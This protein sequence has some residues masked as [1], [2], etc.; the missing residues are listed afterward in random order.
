M[1]TSGRADFPCDDAL[2][3]RALLEASDDFFFVIDREDRVRYVNPAAAALFGRPP[4][5]LIG[6]RRGGLFPPSIAESQGRNLKLVFDSGQAVSRTDWIVYPGGRV[7]VNTRLFPLRDA[8][9]Q[10]AMV[11]GISR[12][13]GEK[14]QAEDA[15]EASEASYRAVFNAANDA[16]FIHDAA[17]GSILDANQRMSELYGYTLQEVLGREP[18]AF[19]SGEPPYTREN[20]A[21]LFQKAAAGEDQSFEWRVRDRAGEA[22]WVE[23]AL[24]RAR[25]GGKDCVLAVVRDIRARKRAT[26][27]LRL[28]ELQH[29]TTLDSL[30]DAVHVTD[31]NFRLVLFNRAFRDWVGSLGFDAAVEGRTV[32][33]AFPFLPPSVRDEYLRVLTTGK[34]LVTEETTNLGGREVITETRKIPV[35]EGEQV[36]RVITVV[37][38]ITERRRLEQEFLKSQ[39]LDTIG[40]LAGGIAHDFNNLLAGIVTNLAVARRYAAPDAPLARAL[41][42]AERAAGRA[43]GLTL[44]LLTFSGGGSPVRRPVALAP[45]LRETAE[46]ALAGSAVRCELH[47]P[48][49]LWPA[50]ADAEQVSQVLQNLLIN[51]RQAMPAGGTVDVVAENLLIEHGNSLGLAP[52]RFVRI[53]VV[54]RGVGIPREN[55]PRIFDPFFTT[56]EGGSG[57]GLTASYAIVRKHGGAL[58]VHSELGAGTTFHAYLPAADAARSDCGPQAAAAPDGLMP[59]L[60]TGRVLLMDDDEIVRRG[61]QRLLRHCGYEVQ[62]AADGAQA[63]ELYAQAR[64]A[65]RPVDAVILDL[66]VLDGMSGEECMRRLRA[67]DPA[68][69]AVACSGYSDEPVLAGFRSHGF[70]AVIRKPFSLEELTEVLDSLIPPTTT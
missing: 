56:K 32:F 68:V 59:P 26:E 40:L 48:D 23:V 37:R 2:F 12:D 70:Q 58:D 62:C 39:K 33:E 9:G 21:A 7:W 61:A 28:S 51:A 67:L 31:R 3:Y 50:H 14:K 43:R 65:G 47:V 27:A 60:R 69:R 8:A 57:L 42:E 38:D 66:T 35:F 53:G 22:F 20:A 19:S 13:L 5:D 64:A 34:A 49:A 4:H 17:T 44:R 25:I 11:L 24:K 16:I 10:V 29:R 1:A 52:G 18:G 30:G 55:L 63:V 6:K 46:L 36:S 54:D 41:A 15:L 45:I